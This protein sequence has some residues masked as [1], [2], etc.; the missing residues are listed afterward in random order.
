MQQWRRARDRRARD[1]AAKD[2]RAS[3]GAGAGRVTLT[4]DQGGQETV[5]TAAF[6]RPT[7]RSQPNPR[8]RRPTPGSASTSNTFDASPTRGATATTD[9]PRAGSTKTPAP[10]PPPDEF[11]VA[12]RSYTAFD[13]TA[14]R[15]STTQSPASPD[16]RS[17]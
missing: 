2:A 5:T 8:W 9:G 13:G 7:R 1:A 3:S 4:L 11:N 14:G 10:T 16:H 15:A 17:T 6:G 12:P